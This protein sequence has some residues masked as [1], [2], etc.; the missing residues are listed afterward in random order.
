MDKNIKKIIWQKCIKYLQNT[1]SIKNFLECINPLQIYIKKNVITILTP[2]EYIKKRI[3]KNYISIIENIIQNLVSKK[4]KIIVN[5]GAI[6]KNVNYTYE[7]NKKTQEKNTKLTIPLSYKIKNEIDYYNKNIPIEKIIEYVITY[8]NIPIDQIKNKKRTKSI[9]RIRQ[10][11]FY[12]CKN[13]TN[14]SLSEIGSLIGNYKHPTVLYS[15]KKIK[16]L[17]KIKDNIKTE[18]EDIT[19][20]ILK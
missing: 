3:E 9:V 10:I 17:I 4:Y 19:K 18:I 6:I 8:Y 7:A 1:I 20:N 16:K 11:I 2:N 14:L 13:F 5:I 12:L 15:Y